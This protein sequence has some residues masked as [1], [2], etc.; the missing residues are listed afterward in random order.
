MLQPTLLSTDQAMADW[1]RFVI[2]HPY[3]SFL[4]TLHWGRVKSGSWKA[5]V[6][7]VRDGERIVAGAQVLVRSLPLGQ[8][9]AYAPYGPLWDEAQPDG[10]TVL[11]DYLRVTFR[12]SIAIK[13][14]VRWPALSPDRPD[15]ILDQLVQSG[16]RHNAHCLQPDA[17]LM[18]DLRHA[19]EELLANMRQT[20]RRYIRQAERAGLQVRRVSGTDGV[21]TFYQ[22]MEQVHQRKGFGIHPR[23]YY[24]KVHDTFG[25]QAFIFTIEQEANVL[26]AYFLLRMEQRSWEM[27][28]GVIDE[29]QRL[30][31][32]YL[33]K[34]RSIQAMQAAGVVDYD[35]WGV[36]PAGQGEHP[37][38]GVTYFK[39][40]FGGQRLQWLGGWDY[41]AH[42]IIYRLAQLSGKL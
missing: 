8:S 28:G 15:A 30:K 31:A 39:E 37:L 3:G 21:A 34:W 13:L 38:A 16:F 20:T 12:Q 27:Y 7:V 11:L 19:E 41:A 17:T 42:P 9:L 5:H 24:Q 36:A 40:G 18:L 1:D 26:G 25:E 4:Q 32:N 10:L 33:L 6:C 29:G 2:E 23:A 35:Q 14:E 22:V